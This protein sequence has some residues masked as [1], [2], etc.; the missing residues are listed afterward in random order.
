MRASCARRRNERMEKVQ[1]AD[2]LNKVVKT[3][4]EA[5]GKEQNLFAKFQVGLVVRGGC[6]E[7]G[8]CL[9]ADIQ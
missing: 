7:C 2:N 6:E 9:N 3:F 4:I 1:G 5:L 8:W